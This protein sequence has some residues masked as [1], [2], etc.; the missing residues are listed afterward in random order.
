MDNKDDT[1]PQ[2][3]LLVVGVLTAV[4]LISWFGMYLIHLGR[5]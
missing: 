2:G 5:V 3:A 4:I 1:K